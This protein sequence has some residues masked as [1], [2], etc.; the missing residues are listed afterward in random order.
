M[1]D[2]RDRCDPQDPPNGD[3]AFDTATCEADV[4]QP[5]GEVVRKLGTFE[6]FRHRGYTL[7]WSGALVSN[8]G[9][10]M[11]NAALALVV[12]NFRKSEFDLGM[13]NFLNGIP[14]L[15]LALPAGAL[16]D[17]LDKKRMIIWAQVGLM[18]QAILLG[19][20]YATGRLSSSHVVEALLWVDLLTLVAGVLTALTFP[21]WQSM[22]PDLVP[23]E[24]LLNAIA[25]N[26]AQ[27]QSARMIGP[28]V[29]GAVLVAAGAAGVFYLNAAS[30][31]FVIAALYFVKLIHKQVIVHPEGE[32]EGT[33]ARLAAGVHYA[34]RHVS[35]R[36]LIISTAML[37]VFGFPYIILMPAVADKTL[38][39]HGEHARTVAYT[40]LLTA[41][42]LGA[43][44]GSL[45]VASLPPTVRRS[46]LLRGAL[47]TLS[48]LLIGFAL[49]RTFWLSLILSTFAGAAV[50]TSNSLANTSIQ[51]SVPP[52]LRGRVMALFIMAFIG[53]MPI[54]GAIF[55]PLGQAIGP[56]N[57][58]LGGALLLLVWALV[59]IFRPQMLPEQQ[60]PP[61]MPVGKTPSGQ[62]GPGGGANAGGADDPSGGG[63]R[64]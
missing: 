2:D 60:L 32:A 31:L 8:V 28:L 59:L 13:V 40:W 25:L 43:L 35:T 50:L 15:F 55:G 41:N 30:F 11:Q 33:W 20:L 5:T 64:R 62:R 49:S 6:A 38:G 47:L 9:T 26:S 21:A 42:G 58:I 27:F 22:L 56:S 19:V 63:A 7:F 14:A 53:I 57:A 54:S 18:I 3:E 24:T 23:R 45:A 16:A 17:R 36:T 44:F 37:T 34:R 51:S 39:F 12:Y 10:W 48:L 52:H 1:P 29:G 4:E 61:V 46:R